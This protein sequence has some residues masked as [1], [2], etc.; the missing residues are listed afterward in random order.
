M[1]EHKL[2]GIIRR[3]L[4]HI[5]L[6]RAMTTNVL[7]GHN[8]GILLV[9]QISV[10]CN[11]VCALYPNAHLLASKFLSDCTNYYLSTSSVTFRPIKCRL[12]T[13]I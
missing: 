12:R 10:Q 13:H 1:L 8:Q 3:K 7:E 5:T 6:W 9:N 4:Q 11:T 2:I